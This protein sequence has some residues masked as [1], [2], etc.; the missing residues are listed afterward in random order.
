MGCPGRC[1]ARRCYSV[2]LLEVRRAATQRAATPRRRGV[3]ASLM[4]REAGGSGPGGQSLASPAASST[5]T[6]HY[7]L[8]PPEAAR[9][10][11]DPPSAPPPRQSSEIK[12]KIKKIKRRG[13]K[14]CCDE[15]GS[16]EIHPGRKDRAGGTARHGTVVPA[17]SRL[18][19]QKAT[20]RQSWSDYAGR[21]NFLSAEGVTLFVLVETK[22]ST[23]SRTQ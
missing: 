12:M 9:C 15:K 2:P 18:F 23:L 11:R 22:V 3:A 8:S 10:S 6:L 21:G 16:W 17:S 19:E 5:C 4:A 20:P 14:S 13:Q 7:Y 1:H